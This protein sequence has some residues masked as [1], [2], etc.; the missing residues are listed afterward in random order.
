MKGKTIE[1]FDNGAKVKLNNRRIN[2]VAGDDNY[3][4]EFVRF[5]KGL[6]GKNKDKIIRQPLWLSYEAVNALVNGLELFTNKKI[7]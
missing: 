3:Y 4:I 2:I 5:D 7:F 6:P 1:L